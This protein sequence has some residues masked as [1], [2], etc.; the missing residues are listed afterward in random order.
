MF[1]V[2]VFSYFPPLLADYYSK[3]LGIPDVLGGM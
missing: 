2:I 3:E 1:Q